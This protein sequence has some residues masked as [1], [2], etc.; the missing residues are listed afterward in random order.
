MNCEVMILNTL[1][2]AHKMFLPNYEI[3]NLS[4]DLRMSWIESGLLFAIVI[5]LVDFF[6]QL[7]REISSAKLFLLAEKHTNTISMDIKWN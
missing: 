4:I 7:N 3:T 1:Y 5:N 6:S 2:V